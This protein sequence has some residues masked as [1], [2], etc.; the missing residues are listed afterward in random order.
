[1]GGL[2]ASDGV[3]WVINDMAFHHQAIAALR[4]AP[5]AGVMSDT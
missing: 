3:G 5:C 1:M 4:M 2:V